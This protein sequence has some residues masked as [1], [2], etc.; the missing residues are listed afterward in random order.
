VTF[1]DPQK[2][3]HDPAA[4]VP[5]ASG[6]N[7]AG[8]KASAGGGEHGQVDPEVETLLTDDFLRRIAEEMDRLSGLISTVECAL[9]SML[10]SGPTPAS[11]E[12]LAALQQLDLIAQTLASLSDFLRSVKPIRRE[13]RMRIGA[14]LRS[15][16]LLDLSARLGAPEQG[17]RGSTFAEGDAGAKLVARPNG[18]SAFGVELF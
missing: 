17:L 13:D 12:T 8:D 9:P 10:S 18:R 15:L 6:A 14:A 4:D 11:T 16:T 5:P 1:V 2:C 3:R 7:V